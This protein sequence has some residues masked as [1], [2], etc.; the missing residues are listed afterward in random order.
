MTKVERFSL[1]GMYG[2]RKYFQ[3]KLDEGYSEVAFGS[4]PYI[5]S[6]SGFLQ[7]RM[8]GMFAFFHPDGRIVTYETV[9]QWLE[10]ESDPHRGHPPESQYNA[11]TF[12]ERCKD[13]QVSLSEKATLADVVADWEPST[14]FQEI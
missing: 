13:F 10:W 9:K 11:K 12:E 8:V 2:D 4:G 1:L 7:K 6:P 14:P 5:T 3:K